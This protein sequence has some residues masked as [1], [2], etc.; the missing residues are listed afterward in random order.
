MYNFVVKRRNNPSAEYLLREYP[1][2]L[3]KLCPCALYP[4]YKARRTD[5]TSKHDLVFLDSPDN[6]CFSCLRFEGKWNAQAQQEYDTY[7]APLYTQGEREEIYRLWKIEA[8][9]FNDPAYFDPWFKC[10]EDWMN[11]S[12]KA[13]ST[14]TDQQRKNLRK[15]ENRKEKQL[16][17]IEQENQAAAL[18]KKV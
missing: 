15:R 7:Y 17:L 11:E 6:L 16:Q 12:V 2:S 13:R 9:F 3:W 1:T 14:L 10:V 5:S 4:P 8:A 18:N